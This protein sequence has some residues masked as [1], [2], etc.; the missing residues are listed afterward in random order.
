MY[1]NFKRYGQTTSDCQVKTNNNNNKNQKTGAC[2]ECGNIENIKKNWPQLK[3]HGNGNRDGVAQGRSYALGGRHASSDSNVTTGTFLLNNRYALI[4]FDTGADMSF[5]STTFSALIDIT[6]TTLENHYDVELGDGKIIGV[7]TILRG[8]TL[9]FMNHPC[10]IDLMLVPLE[11]FNVIIGMDWLPKYHGV[12]ICDK[13][14]VR[15]SFR[16]EITKV[17]SKGCDVFLAHITMKEAKDKSQRKQLE[18]V[19]IVRDFPEVF[20]EDLSCIPPARQVEFQTDLVQGAAPVAWAPY[21]LAP[22][23]MKELGEHEGFVITQSHKRK[24]VEFKLEIN[25]KM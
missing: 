11:S 5:V 15:V 4:L 23:E 14:I 6:P 10:N 13:K 7:N 16:R 2:Y 3:N 17:L 25:K 24:N 8:C 12:I 1:G 21:R 19:S 22:S 20:L 9:N 18:D